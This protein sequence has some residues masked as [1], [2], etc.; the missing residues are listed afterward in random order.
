MRST[1]LPALALLALA[2]GAAP[3]P[4][5]P[6]A[7]ESSA[8]APAETGPKEGSQLG[9]RAPDFILPTSDGG[10]F[11]LSDQRGKPV[12]LVFFRGTW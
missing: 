8:P 11:S 3:P 10:G 6:A 7:A 5:E 12:V 9:E 1:T 2:C 4:Q